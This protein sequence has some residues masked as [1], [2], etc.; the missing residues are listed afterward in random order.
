M[1]TLRAALILGALAFTTPSYAA[2]GEADTLFAEGRE[3]LERGRFVE[4]CEKLRKSEAFASAFGTLLNLGYCYEQIQRYRSAMDAYSEA[5]VLAEKGNEDKK[6]KFAKERVKILEP[7]VLRLV[8]RVADAATSGIEVK[9]NGVVVPPSE[10]GVEVPVDP[11]DFVITASAPGRTSWKGA[12]VG[13]GEGAVITVVVPT[14][15]DAHGAPAS[16][17]P[18]TGSGLELSTKRWVALGLGGAALATLGAGIGLGLGAKSR[19]D[20]SLAHCDDRGCDQSA[21]DAQSGAVAQGNVATVLIALGV[22][23]AGGGAYL[24]FTGGKEK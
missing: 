4:A 15:E 14:L 18:K 19:Y 12:V 5:E 9:R 7:K 20:D 24:W 22:L 1:R 13:R 3:L 2:E 6:A 17:A 8:V 16:A 11:E 10:W 23:C 21:V